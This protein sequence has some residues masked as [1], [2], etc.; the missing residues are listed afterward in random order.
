MFLGKDTLNC[1][2]WVD[3]VENLWQVEN[4]EFPRAIRKIVIQCGTNDLEANK[5]NDIANGLLCSAL[6]I[7]KRNS[8]AI[9]YILD[10][11]HDFRE[12]HVRN[13]MKKVMNLS[14]KNVYQF[15]HHR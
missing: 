7:K 13:K 15:Q 6:K 2:I 11:Y 10:F 4:L 8:I 14:E 1:G 3:K 12:T 5:P 9:I